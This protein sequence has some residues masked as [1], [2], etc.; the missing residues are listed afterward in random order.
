VLGHIFMLPF[1]LGHIFM[2]P[3]DTQC[4]MDETNV[5]PPLSVVC[6]PP[7]FLRE[8]LVCV[9]LRRGVREVGWGSKVPKTSNTLCRVAPS[10]PSVT[11]SVASGSRSMVEHEPGL[12]S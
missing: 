7:A 4:D 2:L 6:T 10:R 9:V 3:F 12:Q 11:L 1:E 8:L 5:A